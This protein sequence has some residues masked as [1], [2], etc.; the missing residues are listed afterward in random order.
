[1]V[2]RAAKEH[3]PVLEWSAPEWA[4][5]LPRHAPKF[6]RLMVYQ[7]FAGGRPDRNPHL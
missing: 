3:G 7:P 5:T 1:M 4:V 6:K 2:I